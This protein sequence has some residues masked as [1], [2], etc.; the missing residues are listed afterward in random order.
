MLIT[1]VF[2]K[3]NREFTFRRGGGM[4]TEA[5]IGMMWPQVK[6]HQQLLQAGRGKEQN[7]SHKISG[8]ST[9]CQHLDFGPV[10]PV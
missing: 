2:I 3:S 9:A 4:T 7:L 1:C 5:K 6:K 10:I 8:R